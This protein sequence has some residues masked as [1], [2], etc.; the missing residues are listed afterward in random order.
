MPLIRL[1]YID[2][3]AGLRRLVERGLGREGFEVE[4]AANGNDGVTLARDKAFD[5][6]AL[7]HYMPGMDGLETLAEL[8]AS[9]AAPPII[10]VT[11]AEESRIAIAALKAGAVDYV[12]KDSRGDFIPLLRV[13]IEAA[14]NSERLR[15]GKESAEAAVREAR[16]RFAAL[17]A[18]RELLLREVNH[19]VGNSLQLVAAFLHLQSGAADNPAVRDALVIAMGRVVA[20][21]Q[22]HR[23]LYTSDDVKSV[24]A[25]G[26]LASFVKDLAKSSPKES[27]IKLEVDKIE[28]DPDRIVAVGVIV[29]ELVLNALKYAYPNGSTGPIR[30]GMKRGGSDRV[31]LSVED[32][33]VGYDGNSGRVASGLGGRIVKAMTAKLSGSVRQEPTTRGTRIVVD[34]PAQS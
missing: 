16:D 21:G 2:D 24:G 23:S 9:P 7:D 13:A 26:Y 14:V 1:L 4:T 5:I 32:D 19:R 10:I 34:F 22:V 20:I 15:K 25:D 30:V 29:N 6:V 3:D 33:G 18:E 8:R 31:L 27:D 12:I 28:L 11:A 17:A